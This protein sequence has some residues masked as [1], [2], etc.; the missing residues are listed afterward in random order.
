[1]DFFL[2]LQFSLGKLV[3]ISLLEFVLFVILGHA[4]L[5]TF[6]YLL[7]QQ[8]FVISRAD[9]HIEP[10]SIIQ[11]NNGATDFVPKAPT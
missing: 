2:F 9:G 1:M 7:S 11:H 3:C 4:N 6:F 5:K 8:W 10:G